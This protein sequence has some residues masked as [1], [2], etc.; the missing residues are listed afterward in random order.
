MAFRQNLPT[1]G[2]VHFASHQANFR[3]TESSGLYTTRKDS[4]FLGT[5]PMEGLHKLDEPPS[6]DILIEDS[7]FCRAGQTRNSQIIVHIGDIKSILFR[8]RYISLGSPYSPWQSC[9]ICSIPRTCCL[10]TEDLS[11]YAR[12]RHDVTTSTLCG[13]PLEFAAT[14]SPQP[15]VPSII[16]K[17]SN[18]LLA[19]PI[20]FTTN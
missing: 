19:E 2:L 8:S 10:P 17:A 11:I 14:Y 15:H 6:A 4:L 1:T 3:F 5:W 16:A 18:C 13:P 12:R 7:S 9:D 20:F